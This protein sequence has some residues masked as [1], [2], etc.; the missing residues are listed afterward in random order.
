MNEELIETLRIFTHL[1]NPETLKNCLSKTTPNTTQKIESLNG[2]KD[3][4]FELNKHIEVKDV[5][6]RVYELEANL[7]ILES[8]LNGFEKN[9][10]GSIEEF[11]THFK[12]LNALNKKNIRELYL[13]LEDKQLLHL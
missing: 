10:Y 3:I 1:T 2:I 12:S 6:Q 9:S 8:A 5:L 13:M 7:F 4:F 11:N